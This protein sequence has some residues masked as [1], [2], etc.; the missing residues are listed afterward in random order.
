MTH[1]GGVVTP[2]IV[3]WPDGIETPGRI[4]H[5]PAHIVDVVPTLLSLAQ[6]DYPETYGG[7]RLAPLTGSNFM[8]LLE[9]KNQVPEKTMFFEHNGNRAVRIGDLKAVQLHKRNWEL[10]DLV[11]D[12]TELDNLA[13]KQ[14]D[15]L[16][17][18]QSAYREWAREH[19]VLEWPVRRE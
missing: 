5:E 8:P 13:D 9:G 12:P 3:H 4:T 1:E 15:N 14:P 11:S 17:R 16:Q 7:H 2:L 19:G 18:L 6:T 10:Y